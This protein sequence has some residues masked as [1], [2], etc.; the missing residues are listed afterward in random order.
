MS[1][2]VF[3]RDTIPEPW[4]PQVSTLTECQFGSHL[5]DDILR[6]CTVCFWLDPEVSR[7]ATVGCTYPATYEVEVGPKGE[8]PAFTTVLRT[9]MFCN[10]HAFTGGMAIA[11]DHE[12]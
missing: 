2:P 4:G 6:R 12:S 10:R 9:A 11:G 5:M 7:C 1:R 8:G 3:G